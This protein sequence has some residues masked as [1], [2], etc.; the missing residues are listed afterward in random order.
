MSGAETVVYMWTTNTGSPNPVIRRTLEGAQA[1]AEECYLTRDRVK[2]PEAASQRLEWRETTSPRGF[3][4][5]NR[6]WTLYA[7][8]RA[9]K[10]RKLK[11]DYV[12][13]MFTTNYLVNEMRMED[14]D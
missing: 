9:P 7:E 8:R 4:F 14:E 2:H 13:E 1:A 3:G 10:N 11:S 12:G 5:G 6:F